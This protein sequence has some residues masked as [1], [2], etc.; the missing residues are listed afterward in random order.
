MTTLRQISNDIMGSGENQAAEF[1]FCGR[2]VSALRVHINAF[3]KEFVYSYITKLHLLD[4]FKLT[5]DIINLLSFIV[6]FNN[7][8]CHTL[9]HIIEPYMRIFVLGRNLE[10]YKIVYSVIFV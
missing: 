2:V 8:L 6:K 7:F 10:R 4:G 5:F 1:R 3:S 9:E